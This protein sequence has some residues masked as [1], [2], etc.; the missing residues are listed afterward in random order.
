MCEIINFKVD[1]IPKVWQPKKNDNLV[2]V[3]V[4]GDV[5]S[6]LVSEAARP[7]IPPLPTLALLLGYY[8]RKLEFEFRYFKALG[9]TTCQD[10]IKI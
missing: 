2:C 5:A 8:M 7:S 1:K 4:R 9:F 3:G 6:S 10:D